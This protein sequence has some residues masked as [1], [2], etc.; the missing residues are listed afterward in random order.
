MKYRAFSHC[1][2]AVLL[3]LVLAGTVRGEKAA[4]MPRSTMPLQGNRAAIRQ[5]ANTKPVPQDA[6]VEVL[7]DETLI[8]F[9][10]DGRRTRRVWRIYRC[11]IEQSLEDWSYGQAGRAP[12]REQRPQIRARVIS[13]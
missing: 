3:L 6:E 10:A 1:C 11:L 8:R 13:P 4:A 5:A 7:L 12:W 2:L 9:E